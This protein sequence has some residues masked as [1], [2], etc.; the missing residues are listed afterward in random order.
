[1]VQLLLLFLLQYTHKAKN[2]QHERLKKFVLT[3]STNPMA[4]NP[5]HFSDTPPGH[6]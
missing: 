6:H 3:A 5:S 1:M 2:R 4:N